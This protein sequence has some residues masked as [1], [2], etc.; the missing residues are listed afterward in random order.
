MTSYVKVNFSTETEME[1]YINM[2]E[3]EGENFYNEQKK[4]GLLRWRFNRYG[5]KLVDTKFHKCLNIRTKEKHK[6]WE[7][8]KM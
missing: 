1:L 5:I 3:K 7:V 2:F 6:D 4:V 8:G